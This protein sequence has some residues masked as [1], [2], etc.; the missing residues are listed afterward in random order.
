M[1]KRIKKNKLLRYMAIA[2]VALTL[3]LVA[4]ITH[5]YLTLD[6]N[7]MMSKVNLKSDIVDEF[8]FIQGDPLNLEATPSNL[9]ENGENLTVISKPTITLKANGTTNEAKYNYYIYLEIPT[10]TFTYTTENQ[11]PEIILNITDANGNPMTNIT[12]LD[13]GTTNGVTGF[14]ITSYSGTITIAD[15]LEILSNSSTET[16]IHEYTITLTYLNLDV[17]QSA[18]YGKKLNTNIVISKNAKAE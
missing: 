5:A 9:E 2:I 10:N 14:D 15:N 12:G 17:D 6:I 18:N 16:T 8:K 13:Y 4:R 7:E 1:M 3:A 11:T